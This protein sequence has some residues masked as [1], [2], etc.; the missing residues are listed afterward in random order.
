MQKSDGAVT[1][2]NY[3]GTLLASVSILN[4]DG[5]RSSKLARL[6]GRLA[7]DVTVATDGSSSNLVYTAGVKTALYVTNVDGS[8][9]TTTYNIAGKSYVAEFQHATASGAVTEVIR[10]HTDGSL[11][12]QQ[13]IGSDGT[14][15][16]D[17]YD[18]TG[19]K[20]NEVQ[21][22]TDGASLT[23][24]YNTSGATTQA[25]QKDANGDTTTTN[26]S[27][28]NATSVYEVHTDGWKETKLFDSGGNLTNDSVYNTDGST[29]STLYS[30][31]VK[32]A[33]YV[34]NADGTHDNSFF[35]ITGKSYVTEYQHSDAA[36]TVLSDTRLHAD[37]SFDFKQVTNSDGSKVTDNYDSAG[38]KTQETTNTPT[39]VWTCSSSRCPASPA[40]LNTTV[41][42]TSGTLVKID[43]QNADGND[44]LTA[45]T[46]GQTIQGSADNDEF[47]ISPWDRPRSSTITAR[48]RSSAST[49]ERRPIMTSSR[50]RRPW[51]RIT[52]ISK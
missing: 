35:N 49:L 23:L 40:R 1:T 33:S 44:K 8:H 41:S 13:K 9:D 45:V 48:T 38:T 2:T 34:T 21:L 24:N 18:S 5:S 22:H 11:D 32:T 52:P 7:S 30:S 26:Y 16:T 27:G 19:H 20:L 37:G 36:G 39:A 50:S 10:Y 14:K 42:C 46:A 12:Y 43:M 47:P 51:S 15:V 6:A 25:I 31:G 28:G 3:N 4:A 29:S 17:V